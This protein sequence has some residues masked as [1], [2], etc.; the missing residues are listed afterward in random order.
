MEGEEKRHTATASS[1]IPRP[2]AYGHSPAA[3]KHNAH[4]ASNHPK[5]HTQKR[6]L[7]HPRRGASL[8]AVTTQRPHTIRKRHSPCALPLSSLRFM[9]TG[10]SST[11]MQLPHAPQKKHQNP[12]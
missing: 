7:T 11:H 10:K 9:P 6:I 12:L 8:H 3:N 4:G 5:S 1:S 2:T